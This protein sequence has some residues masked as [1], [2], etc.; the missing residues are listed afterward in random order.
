MS[1]LLFPLRSLRPLLMLTIRHPSRD[2]QAQRCQQYHQPALFGPVS[3]SWCWSGKV[4][5]ITG[6]SRFVLKASSASEPAEQ[7]GQGGQLTPSS[8]PSKICSIKRPYTY[9]YPIH[10]IENV[11][12]IVGTTNTFPCLHPKV[13]GVNGRKIFAVPGDFV[14]AK[15]DDLDIRAGLV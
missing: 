15:S 5:I 1:P 2:W 8:P 6:C 11:K 10:L 7:G 12:K 3:K 13:S 4:G 9:T 14:H